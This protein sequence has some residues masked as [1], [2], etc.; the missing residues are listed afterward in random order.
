MFSCEK[1]CAVLPIDPP[2]K[3]IFV[4]ISSSKEAD[5]EATMMPFALNWKGP[6]TWRSW[7]WVMSSC[8]SM[9]AL[10]ETFWV[11]AMFALWN[12]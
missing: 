5:G 2:K 7:K 11:A 10:L 12:S 9:M 1:V 8:W 3:T 4:C 6:L